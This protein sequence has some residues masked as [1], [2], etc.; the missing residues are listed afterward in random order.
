MS[1][2]YEPP[3]EP[4]RISVKQLFSTCR[5]L[6]SSLPLSLSRCSSLLLP[7]SLCLRQ[8]AASW[9]CPS[10]LDASPDVSRD[11]RVQ[12]SYF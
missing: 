12:V 7:L 3:S 2:A 10:S 8:V 6:P 9:D 1:L 4:L 11:V 5:S